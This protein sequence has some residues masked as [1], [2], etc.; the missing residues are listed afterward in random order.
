MRLDS[1][2]KLIQS[3]DFM[4]FRELAIACLSLRGYKDVTLTDGWKDGGTDLRVFELPPNPSKIAFQITVEKDWGRKLRQDAK[5]AKDRLGLEYMTLVC[6]RRVQE[7]DFDKIKESIWAQYGVH[8]N[9]IDS[10]SIASTFFESKETSRVLSI[11]GIEANVKD[12]KL[13]ISSPRIE[14]ALSYSFFSQDAE[15]FREHAIE[16]TII[17]IMVDEGEISRES[18][19]EKA[20]SILQL[21][22]TQ[23]SGIQSAI[24]R[25]IQRKDILGPG[26]NMKLN[27][28]LSDAAKAMHSL[29]ISEE[30]ELQDS[31]KEKLCEFSD[32]INEEHIVSI[33]ED[34]GALLIDNAKGAV[35]NS[36]SEKSESLIQESIKKRMRHLNEIL[37]TVGVPDGDKRFKILEDIA[38]VASA[39]KIGR[40]LFAGELF[41]GLSSV[42]THGLIKAFGA[43]LGVQ[44][45]LDASVAIPMICS[46][47]YKT[48][49]NRF[50][51]ASKHVYDQLKNHDQVFVL[52]DEYLE[53]VATHLMVAFRDY[54]LIVDDDQDL[55]RSENSFIAHYVSMKKSGEDL[56]FLDF[57][58]YLGYDAGLRNE[59]F[60]VA[61]NVLKQKIKKIFDKYDIQ[62]KCL[63]R[64]TDVSRKRAEEAISYALNKFEKKRPKVLIE[65]DAQII[66]YLHDRDGSNNEA[67]VLCTWDAIH[68]WM[69]EKESVDWLV[70]NPA[71]LG[72]IFAIARSN[73]DEGSLLTPVVLAK[74][75]SEEAAERGALVWDTIVKIEKGNTNDAKLIESAKVFK[76]K[77]LSNKQSKA[78]LSDIEL[79]WTKWKAENYT[80]N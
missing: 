12:S 25:L 26:K 30:K 65:H 64:P 43:R 79:K 40:H 44:I 37:D 14:A 56:N 3:A 51:T 21:T 75:L 28:I 16:S 19:S 72:D 2:V 54:E 52:P 23:V 55:A 8:V 7:S 71:V 35:S 45:I 74:Q 41:L 6:S 27:D 9:R 24:D 80:N 1:L 42:N 33:I 61:R 5:K 13:K 57:L 31:I 78:S 4:A 77:Y 38:E 11:L 22:E 48:V 18:L 10:Q 68:F 34:I 60:Y 49:D 58:T 59:E 63:E 73:D 76:E 62:V 46:L 32:K 69:R 53:E 70:M 67:D 20:M 29:W 66:A 50:S 15:L 39:S 17:N 36:G 47:L